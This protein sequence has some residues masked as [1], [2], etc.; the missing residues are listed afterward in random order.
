[1]RLSSWNTEKLHHLVAMFPSIDTNVK[2]PGA[3]DDIPTRQTRKWFISRYEKDRIV[4]LYATGVSAAEVARTV[5]RPDRTV[6]DVL[7]RKGVKIRHHPTTTKADVDEMARLYES[8]LSLAKAD[9][10][11][12]TIR[13]TVGKRLSEAG[14]ELRPK[15]AAAHLK[16]HA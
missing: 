6:T 16:V 4:Q 5:N 14:I 11:L 10:A 15:S 2:S 1:M 9:K 12:G 3:N 8:G 7:R 13:A